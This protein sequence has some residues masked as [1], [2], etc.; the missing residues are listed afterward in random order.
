[1]PGD[2]ICKKMKVFHQKLVEND[3]IPGIGPRPMLPTCAV[4]GRDGGR[5]PHRRYTAHRNTSL[6]VHIECNNNNSIVF[7][8][9]ESSN[10]LFIDYFPRV[11]EPMASQHGDLA[12]PSHD[13]APLPSSPWLSRHWSPRS[14]GANAWNLVVL[15]EFLMEN[16]HFFCKYHHQAYARALRNTFRWVSRRFPAVSRWF[17]VFSP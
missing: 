1:M 2:D 4:R 8:V 10:G 7:R 5:A 17:P 13:I 11:C 9:Y 15:N 16:L 6:K 3:Q 14:V 12:I